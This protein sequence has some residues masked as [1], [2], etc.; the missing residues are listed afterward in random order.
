MNEQ[1]FYD[2]AREV[3]SLAER[4]DPF[5]R[6][7]LLELADRYDRKPRPP[8][9]VAAPK[10]APKGASKGAGLTDA[11]G[12]VEEVLSIPAGHLGLLV[13][14]EDGAD[15]QTAPTLTSRLLADI[16]QGRQ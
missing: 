6:M 16:V 5:T 15:A 9:P 7:R 14:G 1:F 11:V 10:V 12:C 8:T 3:R 2:R 4:A 13:D